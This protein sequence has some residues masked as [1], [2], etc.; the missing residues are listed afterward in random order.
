MVVGSLSTA[1]GVAESFAPA[2]HGIPWWVFWGLMFVAALYVSALA[3]GFLGRRDGSPLRLRIACGMVVLGPISLLALG[4]AFGSTFDDTS[5]VSEENLAK[6]EGAVTDLYGVHAGLQVS[7]STQD[8]GPNGNWAA[9]ITAPGVDPRFCTVS[10]G[11]FPAETVVTCEG[12][13]L[14]RLAADAEK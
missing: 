12:H 6:I 7:K 14:D 5:Q 1:I 10:T 13:E 2:V 3:V 11:S 8:P 9:T 4:V